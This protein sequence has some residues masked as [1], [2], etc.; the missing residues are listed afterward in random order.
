MPHGKKSE[1]LTSMS[2]KWWN[3]GKIS[4]SEGA[5]KKERHWSNTFPKWI[6]TDEAFRQSQCGA[7]VAVVWAGHGNGLQQIGVSNQWWLVV[8]SRDGWIVIVKGLEVEVVTYYYVC[9]CNLYPRFLSSQNH[10]L[11]PWLHPLASWAAELLSCWA[12]ELLRRPC[13]PELWS[14]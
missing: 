5:C 8:V 9:I 7:V 11:A 3:K 13:R 4:K 12:A 14:R 6:V 2:K 1:I 10:S